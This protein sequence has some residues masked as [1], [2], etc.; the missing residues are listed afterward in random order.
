MSTVLNIPEYALGSEFA[1]IYMNLSSC[2][3]TLN[4]PES[5]KIYPTVGKYA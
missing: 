2:A 3:R 5:A 4:M 1:L